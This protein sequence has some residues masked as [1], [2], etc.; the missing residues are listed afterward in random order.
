MAVEILGRSTLINC[1][2]LGLQ[3]VEVG[4]EGGEDDEVVEVDDKVLLVESPSTCFLLFRLKALKIDGLEG[5]LL[6]ASFHSISKADMG[7]LLGMMDIPRPGTPLTP[8][9]PPPFPALTASRC[10]M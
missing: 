6:A 5:A 3:E 10:T 7:L 1:R 2:E 4:G 9:Q 8:L